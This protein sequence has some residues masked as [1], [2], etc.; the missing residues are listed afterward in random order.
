MKRTNHWTVTLL[1]LALLTLKAHAQDMPLSML[2]LPG[3]DWRL[4]SEGHTFTDAPCADDKGNFYFSDM[5][6]TPPAIWK[7]APD[8]AKSKFLEGTSC[9]GLKWGPDGRLYGCVGKDKQLVAFEFPGGKKVVIA[10]DVQPND[11]VVTHKGHVYFTE[12]GKK[13]ITFV[14]P[15]TGEKRAV[16]TGI[17]APNGIT[18][19]PDQGTLA[20]SDS[21]GV[22]VWAMRIEPDG[23]LAHKEPYMTLRT[24]VDVNAK[25]PDGRSPVFKTRSSGD[26]M[27]SDRQGRYYVASAVGVQVFDPT[28]RMSGVLPK[29]SAKF[30]TSC[31]FG[32]PN[33]DVLYVTCADQVFARKTK[34]NGNLFFLPPPKDAPPAAKKQ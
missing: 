8:G 22:H 14:N 20:V 34:A 18:V 16:D 24:E 23:S 10:E 29:P 2:L 33:M 31:G 25:S 4:V 12:T 19:S 17:T 15:K 30:M 7:V 32:G 13:Q 27:T 1:G 21:A 11:L 26:G 5:R 6:S 3:E 28:G 9:S